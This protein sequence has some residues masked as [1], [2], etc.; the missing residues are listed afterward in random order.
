MRYSKF[1]PELGLYEIYE[2]AAT[3][4]MNADLPVPRLAGRVGNIGVPA[5][6]AGRVLPSGAKRVGLRWHPEGQ[7]V[8]GRAHALGDLGESVKAHPF[9]AVALVAAALWGLSRLYMSSM[10]SWGER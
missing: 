7:I 9:V 10:T 1:R 5:S 6:H 2:D 3:H 4:E 8:T